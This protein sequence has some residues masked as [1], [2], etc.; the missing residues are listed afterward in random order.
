M[1][2]IFNNRVCVFANEI[3]T[4]NP[5]RKIGSDKGF[6]SEGTFCSMK[7]RNQIIVLRRS[8]PG[9][10][11]LVDFETM[12][13]DVKNKYIQVY[14]DPRAEIATKTQKSILE[15]AIVYGNAAYEFFSVKYRYDGDKKLPPAKVD[16]YTLN[17]RIMNALLSLRDGRKANSIG[18]GSTRINVWEKL[19]KL[20]NDLLT[21]KDPNGRDIFPH[22][23]PQNWK[24]LKRK[25]EQYEAAR[26]ISEE[27]GYRN[28]IHKSYGN[29]YA[30]VVMNEDA[31]AVMHK[32]ISMHNNLNNVQIMEEYNKVASLM[33]WKPIDSPTTV[34][35]WRQKL[36]L[37]TMAGNKGSKALKN[38]RMKQ[39]HREAPSQ[40]LTYWTLDGWDAELFYQKKSPK[41]VK[42]NGEEKRYM[43]TTYTN[44]KTMVVVLDAC[45]K[46]PVG[47]AIGDHESP[48][49]IR[50]A[51]RNAVRHTEEL[52]GKRYKP[53]QL[54][55][56]NYQKKVMTPF[57]EAMTKYYT[58]AALGNAKSKII[59]PYFHELNVQ[60][61]QKQANWSGFG[62]TSDKDNQPNLEV[63][64]QNHKFIPDEAT[65]VAQLEAIIAQE[66]AKKIDAYRAAWERTEEAR[67]MPFGIEEYLMLMGETTGRTN[68]ITGSG[69]FIEY[70]GER[71][72]FDSFDL[73]LRDH[74]NEDWIVR[75][76]PDD[77]SQ[78]LVSNAKRLKS[79]RVDKE[80]GTLQYMLQRDIKVPMALADQKP[81]H[82]EYRT[83]VDKFNNELAEKVKGKEKDV[84]ERIATIFQRIP[85][86]AGGTVLDR[87][88]IT[89]SKGQH[90]DVRSKMRDDAM[91]ADFTEVAQRIT[92]QTAMAPVGIDDDDDYDYNPMDMNFSR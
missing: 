90:K 37:T 43:Y 22:N 54:Q 50:E 8:I 38:T 92:Q 63:L 68:K 12:R 34:E 87:Y 19:C 6:V 3:I 18:G 42:K 21:L 48:T 69:L 35:N 32:L 86:I 83:R 81:E 77:M 84:D 23:L 7:N 47:Y 71:I 51:L 70:M 33:D 58:P 4:L 59:E 40:A 56:D 25:C 39:I 20:S 72:C 10:S 74:Y 64:N 24:S 44:R 41:T 67:K 60:Y 52:F 53:L 49:L 66:R 82:F 89:D 9:S 15:D 1:A 61:C 91:D 80:I 76:D 36:A 16:E 2:E 88:L 30:A 26:R 17:V 5:Q 14:G 75:F 46:Y 28:V 78:V 57:Y 13:Q 11:A 27:E 65:V 85:E 29:K 55:S 73:S 45:E 31:Q 62:I 79:G